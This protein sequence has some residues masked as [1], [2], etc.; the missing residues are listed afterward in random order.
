MNAHS[1]LRSL[2]FGFLPVVLAGAAVACAQANAAEKPA[3][4][5]EEVSVTT[6]DV[7][8]KV[9]PTTVTVTGTLVANRESEVAADASGRVVMT[10][11]ERGEFVAAGSVLARLDSRGASLSRSA[12]AAEV[13]AQR[14]QSAN[15]KLDCERADKLFTVNAITKAELDRIHAGCEASDSTALAAV[16][17]Q[18]MAEKSLGDA[19]IRAPFAGVVVER[20]VDVGEYVSPGRRIATVVDVQKLR[21]EL[22]IPESGAAA[23]K[24][25]SRVEFRVRA[26]DK[27]TFGA[28]VKYVGPVLRRATHDLVVEAL[29]DNSGGQLRPGMFAEADL[30]VAEQKLPVAPRSALV[31][32]APSVHAFVVKGGVAEER[33]VMLG[34]EHGDTV[35]VL[36]GLQAGERVVT[37]P[38]DELRD[39]VRIK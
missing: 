32:H 12:A 23:V 34:A 14:A 5:S 39:G 3:A 18:Q 1:R 9:V 38:T 26:F 35:T 33:V 4:R 30:A 2:G 16:A 22:T 24:A 7:V 20:A 27:Q 37:N 13:A 15:A 21:L 8:E 17:R 25:G 6:V 36:D 11:V 19:V 10:N 31:G 28:E 29:V